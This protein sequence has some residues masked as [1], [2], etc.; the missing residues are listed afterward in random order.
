MQLNCVTRA[1]WTPSVADEIF[2]LA[3]ASFEEF[4]RYAPE[5][6]NEINVI[7]YSAKRAGKFSARDLICVAASGPDPRQVIGVP[8]VVHTEGT[9]GLFC[10]IVV[11]GWSNDKLKDVL[12]EGP[13]NRRPRSTKAETEVS[14]AALVSTYVETEEVVDGILEL[15]SA[16]DEA[17][18]PPRSCTS[19]RESAREAEKSIVRLT[20]LEKLKAGGVSDEEIER[21]KVTMATIVYRQKGEGEIPNTLQVPV[22]MISRAAIEHMKIPFGK[23][24][25]YRGT[26]AAFYTSRL[27]LFGVK[28]ET[29]LDPASDYTDWLVDAEA[30]VDFVGGVNQLAALTRVREKEVADRKL[31]EERTVVEP[32]PTAD[33]VEEA[34]ATG[35][36][37]DAEL[38]DMVAR[39]SEGR[40]TAE[41]SLALA[42]DNAQQVAAERD[43]LEKAFAEAT[44]A[45]DN[46]CKRVAEAEL[47]AK[48][49]MLSPDV[50]EQVREAKERFNSL[51]VRLGI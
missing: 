19:E 18:E 25:D 27:G 30:V 46:A 4:F 14:A 17:E 43:R 48:Q 38:L 7:A 35:F 41:T 16:A 32:P 2:K 31:Q 51:M 40:Q 49:F 9:Q 1:S 11:P 29:S 10:T 42:R 8:A 45:Y 23:A 28:W 33:V 34:A 12:E 5:A 47:V 50:L 20:P 6:P 39:M 26:I 22:E 44:I 37:A 3:R 21:L 36:M 24:G 15:E 13:Y